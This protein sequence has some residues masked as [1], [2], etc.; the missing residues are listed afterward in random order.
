ME[1]TPVSQF[2]SFRPGAH[3]PLPNC[4]S[5]VREE[6][7]SN[8]AMGDMETSTEETSQR[9]EHK[10]NNTPNSRFTSI[11][12][13]I[14]S[15]HSYEMLTQDGRGEETV[16]PL[17]IRKRDTQIHSPTQS[18]SPSFGQ[19]SFEEELPARTASISR[20]LPLKHP[21]PDLQAMQGACVKNVERLEEHAERLSMTSS[22]EEELQKMK[23]EQRQLN[24][25]SSA[26]ARQSP[27]LNTSRKF[28]SASFSNSIAEVNATARLGGYS[29]GGYIA[30]PRDAVQPDP[31]SQPPTRSVSKTSPTKQRRQFSYEEDADVPPLPPPHL[32]PCMGLN[33]ST[34]PGPSVQRRVSSST[35]KSDRPITSAS[36]DTYRQSISLFR[37][38]DGVHYRVPS[39]L[40]RQTSLVRQISLNHPPLAR[41]ASVH[42]EPVPG[43]EMVFYPA[44][45]P[46]MLNLPQK[47]STQ[48]T[49][50]REQ[51]RLK[52]LS[53]LSADMRRS[54]PWL[55]GGSDDARDDMERRKSRQ[56][57]MSL[58][59]QL[60]ASAF[61]EQPATTDLMAGLQLEGGSAV[62]TLDKILDASAFAP[63]NVFVDHPI[64]GDI[65]ARVYGQDEKNEKRKSV[66]TMLEKSN[67]Q[68][69][70]VK[71]RISAGSPSNMLG[72]G[73]RGSGG[74]VDSHGRSVSGGSRRA[75][76]EEDKDLGE[77]RTLQDYA[78][79]LA[80]TRSTVEPG[81]GAT[82]DDEEAADQRY[83]DGDAE[84]EIS[85]S[86]GAPT[87]LLAELQMRK[88]RQKGRNRTAA[89]VAG[90]NNGIYTTLLDM[91]AV[92][93]LQLKSRKQKHVT[94][95]WE[96]EREADRVNFDDEEV[97][98][99][100]LFPREQL[101]NKG[102]ASSAIGG[103]LAQKDMED[104]EPLSRRRERLNPNAKSSRTRSAYAE[105]VVTEE[106]SDEKESETLGM[107]LK[108]LKA[109]KEREPDKTVVAEE[110][111]GELSSRLGL[112]L[113]GG[114]QETDNA[115]PSRPS[116]KTPEI[117]ETLW[118][119]RRR[120]Q[121]Q[122]QMTGA[123]SRQI[124][125]DRPAINGGT[126]K[127][128]QS[129]KT[130]RSIADS[131][132]TRPVGASNA[133]NVTYLNSTAGAR[134]TSGESSSSANRRQSTMPG[135]GYNPYMF[136]GMANPF[137]Q[138]FASPMPMQI[139]STNVGPPFL[140][141]MH[142]MAFSP[143][144]YATTMMTMTNSNGMMPNEYGHRQFPY[145]AMTMMPPINMNVN[146][147]IDMNAFNMG[148]PLDPKHRDGIERWRQGVA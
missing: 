15:S 124:S 71:R 28:S 111:V 60:R 120:L 118:Q 137:Q 20:H 21:K 66:M 119:R 92:T 62:A 139:S 12:R 136:S 36:N 128:A 123:V 56:T 69:G 40:S 9:E 54:A 113:G 84:E 7:T 58:P 33:P 109:E 14:S 4:P 68:N 59:P 107:R 45:I 101:E 147:A 78:D 72:V 5:P 117:E 126:T 96:D 99:G 103:L 65:G 16:A 134:A 49:S 121:E 83:A 129:L 42:D 140:T 148:P 46:K 144:A 82:N 132:S 85:P 86:F 47:L 80:D 6:S 24:R 13:S 23:L 30:S 93:Q 91:D 8:L 105:T 108:R 37:D 97:P 57:L 145:P 102:G 127:S 26:P 90:R 138:P 51:R 79:K 114:G 125:D 143:Q 38:F 31:W 70:K 75:E 25:K 94:L 2:E 81:E 135:H 53:A 50:E 10:E 131:V 142:N 39:L 34:D 130:R 146:A 55:N 110:F 87:T 112:K 18:I 76:V 122:A 77:W 27:S 41:D 74:T 44:P 48:S 89:D 22:L 61:F 141:A 100:I 35:S 29:P 32:T 104:N 98:L 116:I 73:R 95:A 67:K 3:H 17:Q 19:F 106:D 88:A 1:Y 115:G 52:G 64:V 63:V 133:M 43:E 11:L